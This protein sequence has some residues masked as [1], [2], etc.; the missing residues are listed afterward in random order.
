MANDDQ[1]G[2]LG[3]GTAPVFLTAISTILGAVLFLRFGYAVGS[4]GFIGTV[5][6]ILIGHLVTIPTAMAIA[7]IATNQK[8][9]G[10]GEYFIISRSFGLTIGGTIGV[11][12]YL[13]Q[14]LSVAFYIIA[15]AEA[16]SA[17]LGWVE[18]SWNLSPIDIRFVSIPMM[19]LFTLLMLTRGAGAGVKLLYLV[20]SVLLLALVLFFIGN[21]A[22]VPPEGTNLLMHT[23]DDPD[24]FF[25]VFAIIF[26]AFTGMTAGVGLSGDLKDPGRSIPLGTMAATFTGMAMYVIIAYHLASSAS[27]QTLVED[28]L[29][30]SKIALWGP[31][32]PIG[33]ACAT[34]SSALGSIMVAPRTLQALGNDRIVP[35]SMVNRWL[36]YGREDT[37]EPVH[38]SMV[39]CAIAFLVVLL[40]DL[41]IVAKIISMFFMIT[42]GS[43][44]LISFLEHFASNPSY[45]PTFRSRWY[46][47]LFGAVMCIWLM[48]AMNSFYAVVAIVIIF[49]IYLT[50]SRFKRDEGGLAD[51][52]SGVIF[53]LSRGL[54]VFLQKRE[55]DRKTVHWRP[56]IVII[57][58]RTFE[59]HD[60]FNFLCWISE[61][62]GFGTFIHLIVG[63][64]SDET[65]ARAREAMKQLVTMVEA[66]HSNVY[67][68]TLISPS[69]KTAIAQAVQLP[70]IS[71]KAN[72]M[73]V[74]SCSRDGR[75]KLGDFVDTI[76]L[77]KCQ[78]FDIGILATDERSFGLKREIH[79]WLDSSDRKNE[80]LM[81]LLGYIITGHREWRNAKLKIFAIYPEAEIIGRRQELRA[82]VKAGRIPIS[83]KNINMISQKEGVTSKQLI[84]DRSKTSDLTI[85]GF[86]AE[87]AME[88][89]DSILE[90]YD[91][92]GDILF[93]NASS[94]ITI[95]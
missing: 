56:S 9:E 50:V 30:M 66:K 34:I 23:V 78:L 22:Y 37:N 6:I 60:A 8:V 49:L 20:A 73:I 45:R 90:G 70:G 36:A 25:I 59:N 18:A 24:P 72:N 2:K 55:S 76:P 39:T 84:N 13:S 69:F 41:N 21:T 1:N 33:L 64:L 42:Y 95:K 80:N 57:T 14:A 88:D 86:S 74:F 67:L 92:L 10:G 11:A 19:A 53:Q 75:E 91:S 61:R 54:Q 35:F 94:D 44:C 28:Q 51:L 87:E 68:D 32:I 48:F 43:L 62:Y 77:V 3:L 16:F 85:I 63:Y 38:A 47:S 4:V 83:V 26:P 7:E 17:V 52:F 29:V 58:D 79:I 71:G 93:I 12:L 81:I 65:S 46:I 27:P 31:I 15:F 5:G 82:R 40:G 89:H